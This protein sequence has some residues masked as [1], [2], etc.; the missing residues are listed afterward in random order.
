MADLSIDKLF[1]LSLD[2]IKEVLNDLNSNV[3]AF[4]DSSFTGN[5]LYQ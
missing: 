2:C 1:Y 5:Y 4:E 3:N